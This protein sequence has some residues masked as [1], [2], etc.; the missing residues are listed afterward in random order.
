LTVSVAVF[1][2]PAPDAEIVTV[3][4]A[5]TAEVEMKNPAAAAKAGTVTL[6]GT[7]ATDGLLLCSRISTGPS[8]HQFQSRIN[9]QDEVLA[10]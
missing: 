4:G 3:V 7:L 2:T 6:D 10:G 5:A 8:P 9:Q 1:V